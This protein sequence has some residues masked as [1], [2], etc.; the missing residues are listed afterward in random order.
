MTIWIVYKRIKFMLIVIDLLNQL[1]I[2]FILCAF[3]MYNITDLM[4]SAA[5]GLRPFIYP[6]SSELLDQTSAF[7]LMGYT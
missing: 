2:M 1:R 4:P 5:I 3:A 7:H 6:F